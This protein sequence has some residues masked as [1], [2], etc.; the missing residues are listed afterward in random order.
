MRQGNRVQATLKR[1]G[2]LDVLYRVRL[3]L[4]VNGE[5]GLQ[6][7]GNGVALKVG[8][9]PTALTVEGVVDDVTG[10]G[11]TSAKRRRRATDQLDGVLE[12]RLFRGGVQRATSS[13][14]GDIPVTSARYRDTRRETIECAPMV[15]MSGAIFERAE[16]CVAHQ[17]Y[18]AAL[19]TLDND[20]VV[21]VEVFALVDE[22]HASSRNRQCPNHSMPRFGPQ[23][24][25]LRTIPTGHCPSFFF[26]DQYESRWAF[27]GHAYARRLRHRR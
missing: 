7:I 12:W 13:V 24:P 25:G 18:I 21:F 10:H 20:H 1:F 22:F 5:Q 27:S 23:G 8:E 19:R 9:V 17:A 11:E 2:D 4:T 3:L 14:Q 16:I 26:G 15:G 6:S